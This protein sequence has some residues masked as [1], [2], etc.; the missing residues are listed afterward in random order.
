MGRVHQVSGAYLADTHV[1]L[2]ALDNDARLSSRYR[3]LLQSDAEIYVSIASIWEMSI[4]I[5]LGKLR[6]FDDI[7][8]NIERAQYKI[9]PI[10]MKHIEI[11]RGLPHHHR[12]P[13]DR[14]IIAQAMSESMQVLTVDSNFP[15]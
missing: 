12:D 4:K 7:G 13:F 3:D 10:E 2:W 5:A 6:A 11:V 1:V 14:M 9:L 15:L 8:A